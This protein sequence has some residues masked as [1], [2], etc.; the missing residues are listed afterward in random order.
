MITENF[1][2]I[3][4]KCD[5]FKKSFYVFEY[6]WLEDENSQ[7]Q[8]FL[9]ANSDQVAT[10]SSKEE[11]DEEEAAAAIADEK[12]SKDDKHQE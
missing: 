7:L 9:E 5:K 12:S 6:L 2:E 8:A 4:L 10:R 11:E 1:S 3:E